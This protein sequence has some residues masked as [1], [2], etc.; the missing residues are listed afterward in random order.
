MIFPVLFAK[1]SLPPGAGL[2]GC[3]DQSPRAYDYRPGLPGLAELRRD[4]PVTSAQFP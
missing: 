1:Y 2:S 4:F 3:L